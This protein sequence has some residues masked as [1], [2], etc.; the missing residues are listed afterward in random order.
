[1]RLRATKPGQYIKLIREGEEFDVPKEDEGMFKTVAPPGK[2][3][4]KPE[5][6]YASWVEVVDGRKKKASKKVSEE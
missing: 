2:E 4:G 5:T 1:M 6:K 3:G